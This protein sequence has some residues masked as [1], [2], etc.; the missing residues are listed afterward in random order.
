MGEIAPIHNNQA[1]S[2]TPN[3][4][5]EAMKYADIIARSDIVPNDYR[6]NPGNVLVAI[7]MGLEIGLPPLQALQNI[8]VINGR[9][10]VWGDSLMAIARAHPRCEYITETFDEQTVTATIRL[11]RRGQPEEVR[12]FSQADAEQAGLWGKKG[13]WQ[14]SPKRMLQMRARGFGIR[15]VFADALRGLAVAEEQQDIERIEKDMG[16]LRECP[17]RPAEPAHYPDDDFEKNLPKWLDVIGSGKKTA[18][19]IIAMVETKGRLS[20]EQKTR[21]RGETDEENIDAHA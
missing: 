20:E 3:S 11:K 12:S 6:G 17:P 7:Q 13:P 1:F 8:A 9:P 19:N 15:D 21:I 18:E 10:A 5:D 4:L 14:T 2:L 16:Q